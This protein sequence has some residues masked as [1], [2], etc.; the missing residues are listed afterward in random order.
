MLPLHQAV[1]HLG[2]PGS[3]NGTYALETGDDCMGQVATKHR[4]MA[5][6]Q[7]QYLKLWRG[8]DL[9]RTIHSNS[10]EVRMEGTF[11]IVLFAYFN[12]HLI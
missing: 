3:D 6:D 7:E 1:S 10:R 12:T 9:N 11:Y 2:A 4:A 5:S 8:K